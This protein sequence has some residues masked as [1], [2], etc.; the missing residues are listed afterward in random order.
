MNNFIDLMLITEANSEEYN[1]FVGRIFSVDYD[2]E[3]DGDDNHYEL[4]FVCIEQEIKTPGGYN[5]KVKQC[6][7]LYEN[8]EGIYLHQM[9]EEEIEM[10]KMLYPE[11]GWGVIDGNMG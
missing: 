1:S 8:V 4:A 10:Y 9:E 6:A 5:R 3:Y 7:Y 11:A 2:Y